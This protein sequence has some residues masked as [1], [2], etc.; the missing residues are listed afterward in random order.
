MVENV[1]QNVENQPGYPGEISPFLRT[2]EIVYILLGLLLCFVAF[3]SFI[4]SIGGLEFDSFNK[5]FYFVPHGIM[6]FIIGW[7]MSTHKRFWIIISI[8]LL[9]LNILNNVITLSIYLINIEFNELV[10]EGL[11]LIFI[12]GLLQIGISIFVLFFINSQK[13]FFKK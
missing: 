7:L 1:N 11:L 12:E 10:G 13:K 8:Y 9:I 2:I 6:M 4:G 3:T 5:V